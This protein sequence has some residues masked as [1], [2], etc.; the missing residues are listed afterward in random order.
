MNKILILLISSAIF[1]STSFSQESSLTLGYAQSKIKKFNTY[2]DLRGV[3]L[4][5]SYEADNYVG[6]MISLTYQGSLTK[7]DNRINDTKDYLKFNNLSLLVG[8]VYRLN[9]YF[10]IYGLVGMGQTNVKLKAYRIAGQYQ[11]EK[12]KSTQPVYGMG[13]IIR[14]MDHLAMNIGYEKSTANL[15]DE[16]FKFNNFSIGLGYRF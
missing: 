9:D 3:N 16:K 13:V 8:P 15:A 6:V 7:F 11:K 4:K 12:L 14:P 1:S 5:Y 2:N 10:S